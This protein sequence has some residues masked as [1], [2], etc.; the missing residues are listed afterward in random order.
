MNT[1][2][3]QINA[4]LE[5]EA[6]SRIIISKAANKSSE[7]RKIDIQAMSVKA[8]GTHGESQD[9]SCSICGSFSTTFQ[10]SKYTV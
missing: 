7:Y 1:I 10:I 8:S 9:T 2:Y 3:E 6:V 5:S 4:V